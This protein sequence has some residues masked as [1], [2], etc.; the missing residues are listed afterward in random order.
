[1]VATIHFYYLGHRIKYG[2]LQAGNTTQQL[3]PTTQPCCSIEFNL[4]FLF[5]A[6]LVTYNVGIYIYMYIY[7]H[8]HKF[9]L[10]PFLLSSTVMSFLHS[11]LNILRYGKIFCEID[12]SI[13]L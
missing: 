11:M 5:W 7:I 8:I 6:I 2:N 13:A 12:E 1:M 10:I 9:V 3:L 4:S